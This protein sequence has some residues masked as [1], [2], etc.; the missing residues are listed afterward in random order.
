MKKEI[1]KKKL[2]FK[3]KFVANLGEHEAA[4]IQGGKWN[5]NSDIPCQ[6]TGTC[7]SCYATCP[8]STD[9]TL[10]YCDIATM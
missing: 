4:D 5:T 10:R 6:C 3:K 9:G 8:I 1:S 7:D 2:G